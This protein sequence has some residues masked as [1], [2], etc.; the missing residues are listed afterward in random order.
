MKTKGKAVS[1]ALVIILILGAIVWHS[2]DDD[3]SADIK[4]VIYIVC[5]L[6]FIAAA[7]LVIYDYRTKKAAIEKKLQSTSH[8]NR[9]PITWRGLFA[10]GILIHLIIVL[11][12]L[13]GF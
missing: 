2:V 3:L 11:I 6:L 7:G 12:K 8:W 13:S 9:V 5:F 10:V 1:A 4:G